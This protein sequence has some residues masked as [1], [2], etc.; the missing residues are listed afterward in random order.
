MTEGVF[1][2][3]LWKPQGGFAWLPR[4][5]TRKH[6]IGSG[7]CITMGRVASRRIGQRQLNGIVKRLNKGTLTL[8]PTL[9]F[10]SVTSLMTQR[11]L[12]GFVK[13]PNKATPMLN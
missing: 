4:R 8:N 7:G 1:P 11:R 13:L 3:I 2:K 9:A 12:S 10:A 5:A 6:S